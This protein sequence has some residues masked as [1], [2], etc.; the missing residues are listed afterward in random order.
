MMFTICC[1]CLIH[2]LKDPHYPIG[3]TIEVTVIL[4]QKQPSTGQLMMWNMELLLYFSYDYLVVH[5]F[6]I[7]IHL[8]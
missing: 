4:E 2:D 5:C 1:H 8:I 6:C 3:F 7:N